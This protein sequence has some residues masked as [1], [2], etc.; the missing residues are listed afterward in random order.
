MYSIGGK[1]QSF[2]SNANIEQ[3]KIIRC[4]PLKMFNLTR[5]LQQMQIV[6]VLIQEIEQML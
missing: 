2:F 1:K 3:L 5:L 6:F 4:I